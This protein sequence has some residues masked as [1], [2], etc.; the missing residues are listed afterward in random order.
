MVYCLFSNE[1]VRELGGKAVAVGIIYL[2]HI[3]RTKMSL[4]VGDHMN[5]SQVST[6]HY[7]TQVNSVKLVEISNLPSFQIDLNSVIHSDE[8]SG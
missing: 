1:S 5:S 3:K 8:G 4:S 2:N 7:H 6:S